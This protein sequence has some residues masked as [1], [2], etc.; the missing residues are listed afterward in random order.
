MGQSSAL[1]CS[2]GKAENDPTVKGGRSSKAQPWGTIDQPEQGINDGNHRKD[3]DDDLDDPVDG[4]RDRDDIH[5]PIEQTGD[6][7][8]DDD[9]NH[10]AQH[11]SSSVLTHSHRAE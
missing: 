6:E 9:V 2:A 11:S 4:L 10:Q 7:G 3:D 1:I 8:D 5:D